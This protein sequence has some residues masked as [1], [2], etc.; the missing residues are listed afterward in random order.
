MNSETITQLF[1]L[2]PVTMSINYALLLQ[3]PEMSRE[4]LKVSINYLFVR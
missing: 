1:N 3:I 2:L 4:S